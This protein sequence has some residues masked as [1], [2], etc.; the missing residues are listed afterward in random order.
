MNIVDFKRAAIAQ[1]GIQ[2]NGFWTFISNPSNLSNFKI[3]T[4]DASNIVVVWGDN[5]TSTTVPS[6]VATSH[7]YST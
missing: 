7:T 4:S 5:T 2:N 3:T 1:A 6:N